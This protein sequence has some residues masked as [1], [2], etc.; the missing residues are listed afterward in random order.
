MPLNMLVEEPITTKNG[1][2][3][4]PASETLL[5]KY[6]I[7][8]QQIKKWKELNNKTYNEKVHPDLRP[9]Q[10]EGAQKI[11]HNK[12]FAIFDEQRLGKTP[13]L[14][15]SLA[16]INDL[17]TTLI[18]AP[19]STLG[20][21]ERECKLW[22]TNDVAIATGT[23]QK[24]EKLYKNSPQIILASYK[25]VYLDS[26]VLPEI[27]CIV[28]DEAHRLRNF[29]GQRSK[30][31]PK[32]V[33]EIMKISYKCSRR[34]VLTGTPAANKSENIFPI[35]HFLFPTLFTSYYKFL[36]YYYYQEEKYIGKNKT[37]T[38]VTSFKPH[39]QEELQE[40]LNNVSVQRKRKD[41]MKWLPKVDKEKIYL[42][43]PEKEKIWYNELQETF[44]CKE[45]NINCANLLSLMVAL[46]KLTTCSSAKTEWI[47]DYLE[48]Y[49]EDQVL[50]VSEFTSQLK[51]LQKLIK[52]SKLLIGDTPT[53]KRT[54]LEQSFNKKE[55]KV[56][57]ANIEVAKEG[58]KLEACNTIIMLDSSLTCIDNQQ[59]EDRLLPTSEEVAIKK[60]KQQIVKLLLEGTIDSYIYDQLSKKATKVEIINDFKAFLNK[61]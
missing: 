49:P 39:K 54:L 10:N 60:D 56:L 4:F 50:I 45:L 7:P 35:L 47:L 17:G 29:K 55:F 3:L 9:Y 38:E 5:K 23:K 15:A 58:M 61:F 27:N 48:D 44:E 42:K 14:L 40:F 33:K 30:Y 6:K 53:K 57:L 28:V 32:S 34:Y 31:S 11:I 46:R 24:R 43:Q 37:I 8:E 2:G 36:D 18:I 52:G 25:T 59:L 13:M 51:E 16:K 20:G 41:L 26:E 21:W 1:Y 12:S 22:F 19:K